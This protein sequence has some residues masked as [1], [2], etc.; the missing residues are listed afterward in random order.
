MAKKQRAASRSASLKGQT[1]SP[2]RQPRAK[3]DEG[4]AAA[5]LTAAQEPRATWRLEEAKARIQ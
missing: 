1:V 5:K 3:R 2:A 4:T